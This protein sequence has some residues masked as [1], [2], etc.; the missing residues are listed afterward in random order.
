MDY[1]STGSVAKKLHITVRTLRY[2]DEIELASPSIRKENGTRYY[3]NEDILH[4]EKITILKN[5]QLP[6]SEIQ[7]L[8]NNITTEQLL[9]AHKKSLHEKKEQLELSL[10]HTNELLNIS[11]IEGQVNWEHLIPLVRNELQHKEEAE[12]WSDYFS[13]E[14]QKAL[15]TKLPKMEQDDS[16]IKKWMNIIRRIELCLHKNITPFSLEGQIIAED[17]VILSDEMF[18]GDKEL[19]QKFWEVRKSENK[20]ASL[21]LYPIKQEV[22]LFLEEAVGEQMLHMNETT[23]NDE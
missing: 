11:K 10:A 13:N 5:L 17:V 12:C 8:L 7:E 3:T 22:I 19:E 21:N 2:Y 1:Y 16:T 20:S 6:L 23:R 18:G 14:E 4:I 9:L 15:A